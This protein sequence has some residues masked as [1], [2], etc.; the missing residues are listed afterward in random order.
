[1]GNKTFLKQLNDIR[2]KYFLIFLFIFKYYTLTIISH[3]RTYTHTGMQLQPTAHTHTSALT[4]T[5]MQLQPT[6]HTHTSALT[7]PIH[8]QTYIVMP[9]SAPTAN[10]I[11][12]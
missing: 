7:H 4:H 3:T 9:L 2:N 6:A 12:P 5:G 11:Y 1:M 8:T 10:T